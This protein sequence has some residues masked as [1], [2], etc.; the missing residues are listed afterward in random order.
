MVK[1]RKN[2]DEKSPLPSLDQ[3]RRVRTGNKVSRFFRHIFEHNNIRKIL[4]TNMAVAIIASAFIPPTLALT[5][6]DN[7]MVSE[8]TIPLT[9]ERVVQYPLDK[10][11]LSQGYSFGHPG[12]DLDGITGEPVYSIM[13]GIV[14]ETDYSK[15]AYGNAVL[16]AHEEELTTLYAHLSK[17]NV[18]KG[19]DITTDTIIGEVGATGRSFGDHLHLEIREQNYP[20]NPF[21][22]LPR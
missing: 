7:T 17:I 4:G 16:I 14:I 19:Q 2:P 3:I 8:E 6:P 18:A 15:Y 21:L 9:T 10:I 5:E 22:I 13:K 1:R 11:R 20:I 12:I